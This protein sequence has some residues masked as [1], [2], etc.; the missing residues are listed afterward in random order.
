MPFSSFSCR[1]EATSAPAVI[2]AADDGKTA[3]D[4]QAVARHLDVAALET[5][6]MPKPLCVDMRPMP[7]FSFPKLDTFVPAAAISTAVGRGKAVASHT[8]LTPPIKH[9]KRRQPYGL[10]VR[11]TPYRSVLDT[12]G[13]GAIRSRDQ[14]GHMRA[15]MKSHMSDK[16]L[17]TTGFLPAL[18]ELETIVAKDLTRS[19]DITWKK[20]VM[21]G[22]WLK[23]AECRR[24]EAAVSTIPCL[25]QKLFEQQLCYNTLQNQYALAL[26]RIKLLS[27]TTQLPNTSTSLPPGLSMD[28]FYK[29]DIYELLQD[30]SDERD[31]VNVAEPEPLSSDEDIDP[32][33]VT[34][35]D[36]TNRV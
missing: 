32:L 29:F 24:H 35:A 5:S 9:R 25:E 3:V 33:R 8:T 4:T 27:N 20:G 1:H 26:N 28:D 34:L 14:F 15:S 22:E 6:M 17:V 11:Y 19:I 36:I 31:T 21:H 13:D 7:L 23:D 2:L 18:D 30:V 16:Q 10:P 12:F